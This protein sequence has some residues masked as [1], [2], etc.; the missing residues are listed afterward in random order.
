MWSYI[1]QHDLQD[2]KNKRNIKCD[3]SLHALF[4][5]NTINMFQMN[6]ALSKHIWPLSAEDGIF[7]TYIHLSFITDVET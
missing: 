5:V 3:E 7:L 6:K 4:R 1:R 2:P